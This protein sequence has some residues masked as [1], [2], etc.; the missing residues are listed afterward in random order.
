[1]VLL[2]VIWDKLDALTVEGK[3]LHVLEQPFKINKHTLRIGSSIGIA[4]YPAHGTDEI[5]LVKNADTAMYQAK[6]NGRNQVQIYQPDMRV[7]DLF[8]AA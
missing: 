5:S 3:I 8:D 1:M 7:A 2:P 6:E 4:V